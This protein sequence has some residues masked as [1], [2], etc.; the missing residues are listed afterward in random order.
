[1]VS[2]QHPIKP[3]LNENHFLEGD[4]NVNWLSKD[5]DDLIEANLYQREQYENM[6]LCLTKH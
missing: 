4:E 3:K 2:D 1:M 5:S 6:S